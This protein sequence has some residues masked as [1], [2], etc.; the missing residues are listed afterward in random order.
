MHEATATSGP[1]ALRGKLRRF[2]RTRRAQKCSLSP[3]RVSDLFSQPA[4]MNMAASPSLLCRLFIFRKTLFLGGW[5]SRQTGKI[6]EFPQE[7]RAQ[8]FYD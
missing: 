6:K 4:E 5:F 7:P 8:L 2:G 3:R 1:C